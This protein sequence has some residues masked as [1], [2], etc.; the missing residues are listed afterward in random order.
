MA[1]SS[2][3]AALPLLVA[4]L[5]TGC[6]GHAAKQNVGEKSAMPED[7]KGESGKK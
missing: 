4:V 6:G 3:R 5:L 1:F 2:C 7:A